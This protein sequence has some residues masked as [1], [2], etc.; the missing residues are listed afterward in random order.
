[1]RETQVKPKEPTMSDKNHS[2]FITAADQELAQQFKA[3]PITVD[4]ILNDAD[5]AAAAADTSGE[6][7]IGNGASIRVG[8]GDPARTIQLGPTN[9]REAVLKTQLEGIDRQADFLLEQINLTLDPATGKPRP[10][11]IAEH[12]KLALQLRQLQASAE[13]QNQYAL[14]APAQSEGVAQLQREAAWQEMNRTQDNTAA[15]LE[16]EFGRVRIG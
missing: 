1:M 11:L 14:R 9:G 13:F 12:N 16:R 5:L 6:V 4:P 2:A 10:N 3:Q 7:R 8:T 15:A